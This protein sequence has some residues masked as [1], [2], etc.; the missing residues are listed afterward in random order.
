MT[1]PGISND[2]TP[3]VNSWIAI[4]GVFILLWATPIGQEELFGDSP[5][6]EAAPLPKPTTPPVRAEKI[7]RKMLKF[8]DSKGIDEKIFMREFKYQAQRD[9]LFDCLNVT[10]PSPHSVLLEAVLLTSGVVSR[11][12]RSG[13][14]KTLPQC[15][16][17]LLKKMRFPQ[18]GATMVTASHTVI[19]RVD[20]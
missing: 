13:N 11:I 10:L 5:P 8:K 20:W 12:E 14:V 1:V 3:P 19:W 2:G 6:P 4:L 7:G 15:A 18:T 17:D 16:S 9:G